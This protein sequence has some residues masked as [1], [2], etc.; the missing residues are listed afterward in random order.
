MLIAHLSDTHLTTGAVGA[1]PAIGLQRA[2][3]RVLGL[4]V[5]PACVVITGDLADHGK[6]G[7][8]AALR[9]VLDR[10]SIPIHVAM[11]NHDKRQA[12]ED[13][14]AG[15]GYL[16]DGSSAHYAVDYPE[17]TIVVLDSK[18]P[19]SPAGHLGAEQLAWL[20]ETLGRRP[21]VPAI[22]CVH[23]P[24]MPIALPMLDGMR[25]DDGPELGDVIRRHPRVVRVLA[26]HVHRP[27]TAGF[28]GTVLAVAPST[29]LQTNLEL[30]DIGRAGYVADPPGFLLHVLTGHDCVTH[31]VG[32][33]DVLGGY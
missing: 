32:L 15:T 2:L 28:A 22:V 3:G 24:P 11:G 10:F 17:A 5:R 21:E 4:S 33:N 9:E 7:E 6:A 26:G 19:G 27:I 16:G 14:F 29:F 30:R 12:F 23:H 8:Y 20:D 31:V 18:I 1:A 13:A 25:L